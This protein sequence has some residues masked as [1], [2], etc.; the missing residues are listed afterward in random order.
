[1]D[2]FESFPEQPEAKRLLRAAV[3]EEPAH[4]YL[5]HGP[6]GVGSGGP[7]SRSRPR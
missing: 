1:M 6:A 7:R 2:A 4:A 3:G 5:F